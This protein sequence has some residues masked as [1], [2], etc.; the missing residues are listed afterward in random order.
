MEF[1]AELNSLVF[2]ESIKTLGSVYELYIAFD[3]VK[4][5]LEA[6]KTSRSIFI[7]KNVFD[8]L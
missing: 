7:L 4:M 1:I 5:E 3:L 6:K 2:A 8:K